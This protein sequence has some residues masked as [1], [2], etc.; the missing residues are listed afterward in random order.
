MSISAGDLAVTAP[1]P[2]P[3]RSVSRWPLCP[4]PQGAGRTLR[5]DQGSE[6]AR[7]DVLAEHFENGAFFADLGSPSQRGINENTNDPLHQ[8]F[9]RAKTLSSTRPRT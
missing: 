7:D 8:F 6:M 1:K 9:P 2:P 5:W 4:K 3:V